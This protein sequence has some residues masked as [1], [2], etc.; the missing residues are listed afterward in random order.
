M[1]D[2]GLEELPKVT[3]EKK[4][5]PWVVHDAEKDKLKKYREIAIDGLEKNGFLRRE[6]VAGEDEEPREVLVC[7]IDKLKSGDWKF[8]RDLRTDLGPIAT[9]RELGKNNVQRTFYH[10]LRDQKVFSQE[11]YEKLKKGKKVEPKPLFYI[12][13][14]TES[15]L[16]IDEIKKSRFYMGLWELPTYSRGS[17]P[18]SEKGFES[19]LSPWE[20]ITSTLIYH[21][22][23]GDG[24]RN[25]EGKLMV[26]FPDGKGKKPI[27][28]EFFREWGYTGKPG[29][30]RLPI[31]RTQEFFADR[32]PRMLEKGLVRLDDFKVQEGYRTAD[33]FRVGAR[34]TTET[35]QVMIDGVRYT[36]GREFG[37]DNFQVYKLS[38]DLAAVV[39]ERKDGS[40]KISKLFELEIVDQKKVGE[41]EEGGKR[42]K[43]VNRGGF[44]EFS[45]D[46]LAEGNPEYA[47]IAENFEQFLRFSQRVSQEVGLNLSEFSLDEQWYATAVY[48]EYGEQKRFWKSLE[49]YELD[50]LRALMA[51]EGSLGNADLVLEIGEK[52]DAKAL[53]ADASSILEIVNRYEGE[54]R[55]RLDEKD[56][57]YVDD[58]A[59][60][61]LNHTSRLM[62]SSVPVLRGE[63][64]HLDIH[65]VVFAL[66]SFRARVEDI[67][68]KFFKEKIDEGA[69]RRLLDTFSQAKTNSSVQALALET[70]EQWWLREVAADSRKRARSVIN[71]GDGFYKD[72]EALFA[73]ASETTGDTERE[74]KR[75]KDFV[76]EADIQGLVVDIGCGDGKRITAPMAKYL[77]GK[78]KVIGV[79]RL[80]PS[81]EKRKNLGF[82]QG[83][84]TELSFPDSSAQLITAHWSV[85]NDL[86]MRSREIG[87]LDE[88]A[89]VLEQGGS[90]YLD[91]PYLEGGKGS[92]EET[93]R[94]YRKKNPSSRFGMIVAEFPGERAKH[95]NIFPEADLQAMLK[96]SGFSVQR[97]DIWRTKS[98]KP[99]A[100]YIARLERKIT[101]RRLA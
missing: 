94:E 60:V 47:A 63:I 75:F 1:S 84:L 61:V 86:I 67:Y 54:V 19:N 28:S 79:D 95:F 50:G 52:T 6:T 7:D 85:L 62:L 8:Y 48:Q 46:Q 31:W 70:L 32:C 12:P 78:A 10:I 26:N 20:T 92:W 2:V 98:G 35:G 81:A 96:S 51:M 21:P 29:G 90:F 56:R 82:V 83:D 17:Y 23:F 97:K 30:K 42:Y 72:N 4:P 57:K 43:Y 93:A 40:Y 15:A 76:E 37:G 71:E 39:E 27:T 80:K 59:Q 88:V 73:S 100:T 41:W 89:R 55:N 13:K 24:E 38:P 11:D 87:A 9:N 5:I 14:D 34:S 25:D 36:L 3:D 65:D 69:Y 77:E 99:R 74:L 16:S 18:T 64:E 91:V 49:E 53:F 33:R 68:S 66:R 44:R 22:Q 58:I 101:P 45:L